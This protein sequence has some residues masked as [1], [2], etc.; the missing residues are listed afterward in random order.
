MIFIEQVQYDQMVLVLA[1]FSEFSC[2][3]YF[4]VWLLLHLSVLNTWSSVLT[5]RSSSI[6]GSHQTTI[7]PHTLRDKQINT[8]KNR[9]Q[10]KG[11]VEKSALIDMVRCYDHGSTRMTKNRAIIKEDEY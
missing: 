8:T 4:S 3:K 6:R 7:S 2:S 9:H 10:P 5:K 11:K 1:F